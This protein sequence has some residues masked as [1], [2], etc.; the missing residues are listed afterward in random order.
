MP[1]IHAL[2]LPVAAL[3]YWY[4]TKHDNGQSAGDIVNNN[5]DGAADGQR[6]YGLG[7]T[8]VNGN[9]SKVSSTTNNSRTRRW[10]LRTRSD[11]TTTTYFRMLSSKTT[12]VSLKSGRRQ[13]LGIEN[14]ENWEWR[15][16]GYANKQK[17]T[18]KI[19]NGKCL[20]GRRCW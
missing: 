2:H 3:E 6:Q 5:S 11:W 19:N 13:Y 18:V 20:R 1:F 10:G 16:T 8:V 4:A 14:T 7:K 9:T 17:T 12:S 15:R